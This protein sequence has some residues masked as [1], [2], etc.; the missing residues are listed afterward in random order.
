MIRIAFFLILFWF[1]GIAHADVRVTPEGS[2]PSGFSP[3][4][5]IE[6]LAPQAEARVHAFATYERWQ[7]GADG[8]WAPSVE[9]YQAWADVRADGRGRVNMD[10]FPV[11]SG[12]YEGEDRYGLLWSMRKR[13]DPVLAD[14]GFSGS[15]VPAPVQGRVEL[16]V[17]QNGAVIGE[18]SFVFAEPP[19]L[20]VIEVTE[21]RLNGTYAFPASA[22]RLPTIIL[23]HGS[24]GGSAEGARSL[25]TRFAGQGYAA[26]ALNYFAWDTARLDGPPNHHVNQPIELLGDVRE[27][28][29]GRDEV[30]P[31][32]LGLYGHSKGAEYAVLAATYYPWIKAVAACVPSDAVWEGYGIGDGRNTPD[33]ALVWPEQRSSWSWKD[34]PIPYI[35]LYGFEQRKWFDNTERYSVSRTDHPA[36]TK[37]ALIAI[38]QSNARFLLL[39]GGRDEVWAS[40]DMAERLAERLR[41]AGRAKQ[42]R[43]RVY[44]RAGHQICGDGTYPTHIWADPSADPRVKDPVAEGAA[45]AD[46]WREIKAFLKRRL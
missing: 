34:R 7:P 4:I 39:G 11:K 18:S 17:T 40:G 38:E 15:Q 19:G 10:R 36:E 45:S 14:A 6:G 23:L 31:D 27:W 32:R 12:T 13:S 30:D 24:E 3:G 2:V 37:G 16:R 9:T 28:L 46:A 43:V 35:P 44:A 21:G 33:P 22:S 8:V 42:A 29:A 1:A 25:A 26:F 5:A 41:A 20:T